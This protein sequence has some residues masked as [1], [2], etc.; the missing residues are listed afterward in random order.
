MTYRINRV[1]SESHVGLYSQR[2][3][4]LPWTVIFMLYDV[5]VWRVGQRESEILYPLV[6][7]YFV[8]NH[9]VLK[10]SGY[11][12]SNPNMVSNEEKSL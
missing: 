6:I 9:I 1:L 2:S 8:K 3:P 10:N 5:C 4:L 12:I 7:I 11:L